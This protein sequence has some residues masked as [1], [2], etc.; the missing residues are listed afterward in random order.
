MTTRSLTK[1]SPFLLSI[2]AQ[3]ALVHVVILDHLT[4]LSIGVSL[5]VLSA[6]A[7]LAGHPVEGGASDAGAALSGTPNRTF[8]PVG[9]A[10]EVIQAATH[11]Y[12]NPC[13]GCHNTS[14]KIS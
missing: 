3:I 10:S 1:R 2:A 14:H 5:S 4:N 8:G 7:L 13:H 11:G 6:W 9:A 12:H